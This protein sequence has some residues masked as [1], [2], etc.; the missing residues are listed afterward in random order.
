MKKKLLIL[1][2]ALTLGVTAMAQTNNT[3]GY[4]VAKCNITVRAIYN[5]SVLVT[6]NNVHRSFYCS[7]NDFNGTPIKVGESYEVML[8]IS[9]KEYGKPKPHA[10]VLFYQYSDRQTALIKRRIEDSLKVRPIT[11]Y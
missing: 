8:K 7:L 6:T 11:T 4:D 10:T 9:H 1:L 3:Y 2:M 5:Q